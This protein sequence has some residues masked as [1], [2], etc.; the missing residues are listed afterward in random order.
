MKKQLFLISGLII[1]TSAYCMQPEDK[2]LSPIKPYA[3]FIE[4]AKE[5]LSSDTKQP[6][7]AD[8]ASVF[9]E[10]AKQHTRLLKLCEQPEE[11][12]N[13]QSPRN[14]HELLRQLNIDSMLIRKSI[15]TCCNSAIKL[16][17]SFTQDHLV[18]SIHLSRFYTSYL[19]EP[20]KAKPS[21][22]AP[23]YN[24]ILTRAKRFLDDLAN[25]E[26]EEKLSHLEIV[27]GDTL[28]GLTRTLT[29]AKQK[30]N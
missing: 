4:K 3:D 8:D 6:A 5:E 25:D 16:Q 7:A 26:A 11:S 10:A 9:L 2:K 24:A 17:S 19:A 13:E 30:H 18:L 29:E 20:Q 22:N 12:K 15:D 21:V 27:L 23:A 28:S 14:E 1:S